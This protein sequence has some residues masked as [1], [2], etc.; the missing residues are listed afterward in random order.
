M[1]VARVCSSCSKRNP[2]GLWQVLEQSAVGTSPEGYEEIQTK[3]RRATCWRPALMITQIRATCPVQT[4]P[5]PTCGLGARL[6]AAVVEYQ[7]FI[8][9]ILNRP[10]VAGQKCRI[11]SIHRQVN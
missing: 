3:V 2:C 5:W 10:E 4:F 7:D 1:Y 9:I 8:K 11:E 6:K